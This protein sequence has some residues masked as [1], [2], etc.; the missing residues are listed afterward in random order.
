[1]VKGKAK[2][3]KSPKK[4]IEKVDMEQIVPD[5]DRY[6]Y[7]KD[8]VIEAIYEIMPS[9]NRKFNLYKI[10]ERQGTRGVLRRI[11]N[12]D[13]TLADKSLYY[14]V[15][16]ELKQDKIITHIGGPYWARLK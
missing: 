10:V 16:Q 1:M 8:G 4:H 2:V 13:F 14:A 6:R 12:G 7:I 5:V 9:I 15:L 3:M 11:L